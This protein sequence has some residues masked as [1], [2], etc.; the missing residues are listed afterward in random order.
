LA[1][2][3]KANAELANEVQPT[4]IFVSPLHIDPGSDLEHI[5]EAGGFEECTLGQYIDEE[6]LFLEGLE[7]RDCVFFG[8]H[9]SNPIPVAGWLPRDKET[10]LY[11]L[12]RGKAR[13]SQRV[14]DSHPS[15]GAE[16]ALS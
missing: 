7:Q 11:E 12:R 4:L 13:L 10:L 15:K 1:E 3:A 8:L 5:A 16:G 6:I 14:L 2:H 9:V